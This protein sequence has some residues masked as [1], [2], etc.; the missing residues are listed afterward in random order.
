VEQK[1]GLEQEHAE[2]LRVTGEKLLTQ[3]QYRSLARL[4]ALTRTAVHVFVLQ[5]RRGVCASRA[6]P[7]R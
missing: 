2:A 6:L 7:W 4:V 1:Q 3:E 5:S